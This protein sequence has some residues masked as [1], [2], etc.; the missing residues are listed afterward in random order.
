LIGIL[1]VDD[2][3][4]NRML[5]KCIIH[6]NIPNV[7][8][9][10]A[11]NGELALEILNTKEINVVVL[12][13]VMP[14]K[15]GI[16]TLTEIKSS[17]CLKHIPVIMCSA[18][19]EIDKIEQALSLGALDYFTK[20]LIDEHIKITLP[21]KIKNAIEYYEQNKQ[22]SMYNN[23]IKKEMILV[24]NIQKLFIPEHYIFDDIEIWGKHIPCDEIG[25]DIFSC[26]FVDKKLWF[27]MADVLGHGLSSAFVSTI[28]KCIFDNYIDNN[29]SPKDI[30]YKI[31]S[32]IYD[33]F[34]GSNYGVS[35]IFI[36]CID[37][38]N[39]KVVN[40]GHP[41]PIIY[42]SNLKKCSEIKLNGNLVG[43]FKNPEFE[44][45]ELDFNN[46]DSLIIF[47]DGVFDKGNDYEFAL[48]DIVNKYCTLN[49]DSI[50]GNMKDYI[51]N[52][53]NHFQNRDNEKFVDDASI[54]V[55]KKY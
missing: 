33:M 42:H 13:L 48:W 44:S 34:N 26:K 24:K 32:F 45:A 19:N 25:G 40:G 29:I 35:S 17:E 18:V 46:G 52:M 10:E 47:T 28:L 12:D 30:L 15:D 51:D 9:Y 11:E 41:Y 37:D 36:G 55:I 3:D 6:N 4:V 49:I 16:Q 5:V 50:E 21:L 39:L 14:K 54:V 43:V 53:M 8:I 2:I 22:I 1:I 27:I 38:N 31:N 7:Q 23:R 20:P